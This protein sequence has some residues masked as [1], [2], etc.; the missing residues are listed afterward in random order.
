MGF[1]Q[2]HGGRSPW[3]TEKSSIGARGRFDFVSQLDLAGHDV[4]RS[5]LGR[6]GFALKIN[7][8]CECESL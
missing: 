7:S 4:P 1:V 3:L 6:G 2:F 8:P 5:A